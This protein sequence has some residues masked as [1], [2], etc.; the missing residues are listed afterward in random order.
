MC[1]VCVGQGK[2]FFFLKKKKIKERLVGAGWDDGDFMRGFDWT[3][4]VRGVC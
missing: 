1:A 4:K 2:I 3:I